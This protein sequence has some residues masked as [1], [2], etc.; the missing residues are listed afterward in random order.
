MTKIYLTLLSAASIGL[1]PMAFAD[2]GTNT[3]PTPTVAPAS[4]FTGAQIAEIEA[5]ISKYITGNP[6]VISESLQ[7]AMTL[8]QQEEMA[9]MEKVVLTNK[10]K[11]FKNE[12]DPI[13]GNFKGNETLVVFA[14]PNCHY[15]KKLHPELASLLKTNKNVK[16]IFKDLPIMG[17]NSLLAIKAMLAAKNQGKY[18]EVQDAVYTADKP[19]TKKQIM[20]LAEKLGLDTKKF[21]ADMK[22]KEVQTQI[23][24]NLELSKS[25]GINGTPTLIFG[26]STVVPGYLD[27]DALNEKLKEVATAKN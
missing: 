20:K 8:K 16:I 12:S 21:E 27:V 9:K 6:K 22:S 19:L 2:T 23:D 14:D 3:Q 25:I 15:C 26:A 1:T 17:N 10:D 7:A 5:L 4:N 24:Q 18:N 13:A 11:I